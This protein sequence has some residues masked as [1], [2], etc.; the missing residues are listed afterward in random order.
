MGEHIG[1]LFFS[2]TGNTQIVTELI[3][4]TLQ[5]KEVIVD[6][7][8]IEEIVNQNKVVDMDQYSMIG[9]G[10]P[11][12]GFKEPRI[13]KK[14]TEIL[15]RTKT[16]DVFIFETAADFISINNNSSQYVI[17]KLHKKGY[18]VFYTRIIC[19]GSNFFMKYDD[20]LIK[21][22]YLSALSKVEELCTDVLSRKKRIKTTNFLLRLT[23]NILHWF[24]DE[25]LARIFG[26][27]LR[28][29]ETCSHCGKCVRNC[30]S[31]NIRIKNKKISFKW[32][33]LL[34]M[35]CIYNC[36]KNAIRSRGLSFLIL[37]DGYNIKK[38]IESSDIKGKYITKDTKGFMK[39]F[40]RYFNDSSI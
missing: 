36:P 5:S 34:C 37:K 18:N 27:S 40:Q 39:H 24:E 1:L 11:V 16:K 15:P 12:Y 21:Q 25:C 10:Y 28:V 4:S 22:L 38:I 2:G 33:C 7:I 8:C 30:P 3:Q 19:M 35:R 9:I 29:L 13:M 17:R 6:I 32:N 26:K 20:E 31:K 14:L 23:T